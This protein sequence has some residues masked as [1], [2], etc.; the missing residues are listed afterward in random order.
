MAKSLVV[1]D[2]HLKS[3][4]ILPKVDEVL[5]ENRDISRVVFLGDICDEWNA[6]D[7]QMVHEVEEFT[8]WVDD[9]RIE[10]MDVD[11]LIGN[12]DFQYLL[13]EQGPGT[14]MDLLER[15]FVESTLFQLDPKIACDVDGFLLT[16][17]GLTQ[18]YADENLNEP[19]DAYKA[20]LQLNE[21]FAD[22]SEEALEVL[23]QCGVGRGGD[24]TPGPLWAD[25][26]EL[27]DDP[28]EG[29]P[30]I[31]GHTPVATICQGEVADIDEVPELWFCD[32]FSLQS[33]MVPI[34]DGSMLLVD[35]GEISIIHP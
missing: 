27:E 1:G 16:H 33:D 21:I 2:I 15:G 7:D 30:Q 6:D 20:A 17:A 9:R 11:V 25:K 14:H 8:D 13:K 31:V 28:I 3:S 4:E 22:G 10:G 18:A 23:G 26:W 24:D 32:T 12:H 34:G 29:I 35:D 19:E 5:S